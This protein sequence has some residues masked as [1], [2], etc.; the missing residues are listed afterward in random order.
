MIEVATLDMH[1]AAAPYLHSMSA[2]PAPTPQSLLQSWYALE[3]LTP[4]ELPSF[5][6]LSSMGQTRVDFADPSHLLPWIDPSFTR[7]ED[8]KSLHWFVV[9]G[10]CDLVRMNEDL[11]RVFD[12][13]F[14]DERSYP[15]KN[16][17]GAI[18]VVTV[19][20]RGK[21]VRE[22]TFLSS[23]AWA[24]GRVLADDMASLAA[25]SDAEATF[26]E[27]I[28][29]RLI[30]QDANG[31]IQPVRRD[32][33]LEAV[34]WLRGQIP[35]TTEQAPG[36]GFAIRVPSKASS[37]A[38]PEPG[39]LNSFF[40]QDIGRALVAAKKGQIPEDSPLALYLAGQGATT[41]TDVINDTQTVREGL[42]P[43]LHPV[44][45]WPSRKLPD[46]RRPSLSLMQQFG[47]N[48]M[49]SDLK[50]SGV[51]SVNGPPGTGKTTLLRDLVAHTICERAKAMVKFKNPADAFSPVADG[52]YG[53]GNSSWDLHE[54]HHSL[55]GHEV[56]VASANNA[57][58]EN[59][60]R[61]LPLAEALADDLEP[62]L[63]YFAD[64]ATE[65]SKG[66][67]DQKNP[68]KT[69]L[70]RPAWGLAAAV[71]GNK[72]NRNFFSEVCWWDPSIGLKERLYQAARHSRNTMPGT[73]PDQL[74][75]PEAVKSFQAAVSSAEADLAVLERA[76]SQLPEQ[77]RLKVAR[78]QMLLNARKL[79]ASVV[80]AENDLADV[81]RTRTR[82]QE[83]L[84]VADGDLHTHDKDRPHWWWWIFSRKKH[85]DWRA[86]HHEL[87]NARTDA[88]QKLR[89][90]ICAEQERDGLLVETRKAKSVGAKALE[91][92]EA[93]L[94][95]CEND[96]A[97]ARRLAG[98]AFADD[99]FWEKPENDQQKATAWLGTATQSKRDEVF[100]AA[101]R[102][103][104]SFLFA[105]AKPLRHNL[106]IFFT[107]VLK[108]R[109]LKDAHIKYTDSVWSTLFMVIP[110][111]STTFASIERMLRHT[112]LSTFGWLCI[113]EAGQAVPQQAVGALMRS[114]RA[115]V[116][117]DPRQIP[118]VVKTS[119]KLVT[120]VCRTFQVDSQFWA[121][122]WAS[123]QILA[124]RANALGTYLPGDRGDEWVGSPLRVHHR[125]MEPMFSIANQI[126]YR[127]LMVPA[128]KEGSS[129]IGQVAGV[130]SWIDVV[131]RGSDKWSPA[132]GD[133]L[134]HLLQKLRN[135]GITAPDLYI[136]SPFRRVA[137]GAV[138]AIRSDQMIDAWLNHDAK[139]RVGTVHTFQGKDADTV[140]II[141]GAQ[142]DDFA[143]SRNWATRPP[144]LINV[145]VTR[146][147]R[148]LYVIGS[149][150]HWKNCGAAG[151]V[152]KLMG[153]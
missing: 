135:S 77:A 113:D 96:L 50:E 13:P 74:G 22:G 81:Q 55:R 35:L 3:L 43:R 71:L 42:S 140:I 61:E 11:L 21:L 72:A 146:A 64:I 31:A 69:R 63:R 60:S 70:G 53:A 115:V 58:V 129:A 79:E 37:G 26:M 32:G 46:G 65:L 54:V 151:E 29:A 100:A 15:E 132:E 101:V 150:Y 23:F 145:A 8:E 47:I 94:V 87:K 78:D 1:Y 5:E 109:P 85:R 83:F 119:P 128:T 121:G 120:A 73:F 33:L 118:P 16:D 131:G 93:N 123:T 95:R 30:V 89:S 51:F 133:V 38:P 149:K 105:A 110:V 122:P 153:G 82:S 138:E 91:C 112:P 148:R 144:N 9:L 75:W 99:R 24:A 17:R 127:N 139:K 111:V 143:G 28:E 36:T 130:S 76:K 62:P 136:I 116:V 80:A 12:D 137:S 52:A 86:A 6:T 97:V 56:L 84:N 134:L 66:P 4:V 124:D 88:A 107:E 152:M 90:A 125:C 59:I 98:D 49:V 147:K 108:Q 18:A 41:R 106:G 20:E 44:A 102:V 10:E 117:G 114:R 67:P 19:D 7:Q 48:R 14:A 104:Q 40:L 25:F 103:H 27:G 142:G 68:K 126:A 141:L 2:I 92:A 34:T 39:F 57:A 45:R